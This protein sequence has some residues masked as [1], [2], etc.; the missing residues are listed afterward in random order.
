[1][2][3]RFSLTKDRRGLVSD[4]R[5]W[6]HVLFR[7]HVREVLADVRDP[8]GLRWLALTLVLRLAEEDTSTHEPETLSELEA[9]NVLNLAVFV[10]LNIATITLNR[11]CFGTINLRDCDWSFLLRCSNRFLTLDSWPIVLSFAQGLF[12]Y[13]GP[14]GELVESLLLAGKRR[15]GGVLSAFWLRHCEFKFKTT[16]SY[17]WYPLIVIVILIFAARRLDFLWV[18]IQFNCIHRGIE[19]IIHARLG[20]LSQRLL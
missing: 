1:M 15:H 5:V 10:D 2:P 4:D 17:I 6:I 3:A 7:G 20:R 18:R 16:G 12:N 13:P 9:C 14:H 19:L 11:G 8:G